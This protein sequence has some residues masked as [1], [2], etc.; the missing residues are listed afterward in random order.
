MTLTWEEARRGG[1]SS[2]DAAAIM[3]KSARRTPSMVQAEKLAPSD[4]QTGH[5]NEDT[6]WG[7]Q[8]EPLVAQTFCHRTGCAIVEP[9]DWEVTLPEA[10][11]YALPDG[12]GNTRW[13]LLSRRVPVIRSTPDYVVT[14]TDSGATIV[15]V[16]T[17]SK[18]AM[19]KDGPP[20]SVLWQC[21]WHMMAAGLD[22]CW[23]PVLMFSPTRQLRCYRVNLA[24]ECAPGGIVERYAAEWWDE[25]VVR[26]RPCRR[27]GLDIPAL[28]KKFPHGN[29]TTVDLPAGLAILDQQYVERVRETTAM[30]A[31]LRAS[32]SATKDVEVLLREAIG[33]ASFGR[34]EGTNVTYSL[35]SRSSGGRV[36]R[37]K[38]SP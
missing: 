3:G 19:W 37:R 1:L 7:N 31:K 12:Q 18:W 34:I 16:K 22:R 26:Q 10:A 11:S 24:D 27:S 9:R 6:F 5:L 25:H 33:E 4:P 29:G 36:L 21:Q 28:T 15:E 35:L 2:S 32:E 23:V 8:M 38:P 20:L 30:R 17:T 14:D 13:M